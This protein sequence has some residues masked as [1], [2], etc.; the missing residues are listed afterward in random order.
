MKRI[1]LCVV[2]VA[3]LSGMAWADPPARVG[4]LALADGNVSFA[5]APGSAW[6]AASVN[7][8]LTAGNQ[9]STGAGSRA[10]IQ[11]GSAALRL[12]PD[13]EMSL[14]ALDD[15][16]TQVRLDKGRASVRLHRLDS[17]ETFQIDTQTASVS[18][19]APGS[20]R[21]E[22]MDSG[23]AVIITRAGDAQVTGGQ[24]SFDVRGE[25][26][27][28]IPAQ[29]PDGYHISSAPPPDQ[30]DEWV[31][32]RDVQEN[33]GNST[34][35]VS[36]ETD[37]A[38]DLDQYGTW[39]V[40]AG[41]GPVW[42]PTMVSVGW[43][44]YTFGHWVWID[45]WGWTWVDDE[46]W[47][48]APFHY[49]RWALVT[50]TWCW[51]PGPIVLHPVYAPALVRWV[52]GTPWRGHPPNEAGITWA[53]L[54]PRQVFHPA[55][56]VSTTYFRAVNATAPFQPRVVRPPFARSWSGQPGFASRTPSGPAPFVPRP[57]TAARPPYGGGP[58]FGG[59]PPW[60]ASRGPS[61]YP[62]PAYPGSG[63]VVRGRPPQGGP[64]AQDPLLWPDRGQDRRAR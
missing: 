60:A 12:A 54:G 47:G 16:T 7:Y 52:G 8:P 64:T 21:V 33:Q 40:L 29:G 10:E 20:Y 3:A 28:E 43:A 24:A 35:Y 51:V 30:W 4:R 45:P 11:I 31:S 53:P 49:G 23:G 5:A 56:R 50:G 2:G 6:Q 38:G 58:S 48:F 46:P 34:R 32:E 61:A 27:A 39:Q 14:E 25:Q 44:P 9:L 13:T 26:M 62:Q 18:L 22:Q 37:G 41:Y 42:Y 55:Y 59:R 1:L 36:S 57:A 63:Q 19:S 17:N 15:Q